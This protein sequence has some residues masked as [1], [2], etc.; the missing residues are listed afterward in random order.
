LPPNSGSRGQKYS[1]SALIR[2]FSGPNLCPSNIHDL[3]PDKV[4]YQE[5]PS[6]TQNKWRLCHLSPLWFEAFSPR[7]CPLPLSVC[8]NPLRSVRKWICRSRAASANHATETAGPAATTHPNDRRSW[9]E[10][11]ELLGSA[12]RELAEAEVVLSAK[13]N[14]WIV[15]PAVRF[16]SAKVASIPQI[17]TS[18]GDLRGLPLISALHSSCRRF[19]EPPMMMMMMPFPSRRRHSPCRNISQLQYRVAV[20]W[21]IG[22]TEAWLS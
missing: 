2:S 19:R 20:L 4:N 17:D 9:E 14:V 6:R 15:R 22:L 10:P 13:E 8:D 5:L 3:T 21:K 1:S 16:N 11:N 12:K 18:G 7:F